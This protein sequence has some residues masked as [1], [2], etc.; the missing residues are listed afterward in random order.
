VKP[1]TGCKRNLPDESFAWKLKGVR[2]SR[3]CR[4]CQKVVKDAHYRANKRSY[5]AKARKYQ[6]EVVKTWMQEYKTNHPCADCGNF[7]HYC[8]MD[9]DHLGDKVR[10]VSLMASRYGRQQLLAEIAKCDLVCSNCHRLRT[11]RR[12]QE[13]DTPCGREP[14]FN[15][16]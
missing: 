7:Y 1:C 16:V 8:Q 12:R 4:D 9:F 13:A 14:A 2:R 3:R 15:P 5:V 6:N 10:N 11:F